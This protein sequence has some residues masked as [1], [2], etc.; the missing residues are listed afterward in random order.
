V[1]RRRLPLGIMSTTASIAAVSAVLIVT[2]LVGEPAYDPGFALRWWVLAAMFCLTEM[3]V[4]HVQFKRE[5]Q[6]FSLNEL[7][8]VLGLF[9]ATPS[10]LIL[11]QI[12]G[13]GAALILHR[14][15]PVMKWT[16]NLSHFTLSAAIA[17]IAF[18]LLA[19]EGAG[20]MGGREMLASFT[21]AG[22]ALIVGTFAVMLAIWVIDGRPTSRFVGRSLAF[23]VIGAMTNASLAL[24]AVVLLRDDPASAWL[25]AGPSAILFLAY[26][27]YTSSRMK[28]ETLASLSEVTR[29]VQMSSTVEPA[30]HT[31]LDQARRLM[32][33]EVA[34]I[35]FLP[36]EGETSALEAQLAQDAEMESLMAVELDPTKGVWARVVAEG[37]GI[38]LPRPIENPRLREH[39]AKLGMRDAIVAPLWGRDRIIGFLRV[40][41]RSGDVE[42][43]TTDD[44]LLFETFVR[45]VGIALENARLLSHLERSVGS[46]KLMDQL[47]DE[48]L[49]TLSHELRSPLASLRLHIEEMIHTQGARTDEG[50][51]HLRV[52][53]AQSERLRGIIEDLLTDARLGSGAVTSF[54]SK[55][56]IGDVLDRIVES[57]ALWH[58][59]HRISVERQQ[60][61]LLP[62]YS[63]R[64]IISSILNNLVSNACKYSPEG[65]T[66]TLRASEEQDG[67]KITVTDQGRGIAPELHG[68]VFD[69]FFR[70]ASKETKTPGVGLG[71]SICTRLAS[72]L[73]GRVALERSRPGAGSVFS[74][75]VPFRP[76]SIEVPAAPQPIVVAEAPEPTAPTKLRLLGE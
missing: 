13:A 27:G 28:H 32:R 62:V 23:G 68:Q 7:P 39:F 24:C 4:V 48:V 52:M 47:K 1:R 16:F 60:D 73:G 53:A 45:H 33:A 8:L 31:V 49:A 3:H 38:L 69:R 66:V 54:P 50:S 10:D 76:P 74:L 75:W 57:A 59:R 22:L 46:L 25:L 37:Q 56:S 19:R 63:D 14:R 21:A 20:F 9:F 70:T 43:F 44:L 6:T 11:G 67:I 61:P 58:P 41:N 12:I 35:T 65:T 30:M 26:R 42:T 34:T 17:S 64:D 29:A 51:D 5:T 15:Q 18:R 72:V 2:A 55:T 40:G 71:L 36:L